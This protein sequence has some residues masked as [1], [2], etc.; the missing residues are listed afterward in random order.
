MRHFLDVDELSPDELVTVLDRSQSA[1]PPK[2]LE[3][4]SVGLLFQKPSLRTRHSSEVAVIQL[5]GHPVTFFGQEVSPDSRE[6]LADIARVLAGYHAVLGARVF[7]HGHLIQLAATDALP[8]VNLLSDT[9]HPCQALA[10]LLTIRRH[11]GSFD[12]RTI[13]WVGDYNN[14]VRSLARGA[15]M[16]GVGLRIATPAGYGPGP[17]EL[18][19]LRSLGGVVDATDDPIKAA[20]GAD[21][22]Y[23][24][25]W[26]SMGFELED[27]TRHEAFAGYQV[28][29]A[30]MAAAGPDA[31]FLHCL[32]AHR[33][34]EVSASV[35]DGPQSLVF[36]QAHNRLAAFR[37][38]LWWLVEVNRQTTES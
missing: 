29:D 28:D 19:Y 34:E 25:V 2:V 18:D 7:D 36:P 37:G 5:G 14:T 10:D 27:E 9:A 17:A 30:V 32:P 1:D 26:T 23:T 20:D 35:V 24:D 38:L 33:G 11:F 3:G 22:I 6:P 21:V 15:A 12:D 8:I 4:R 13:C 31:V 16:L